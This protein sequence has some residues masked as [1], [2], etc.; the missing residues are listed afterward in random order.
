MTAYHIKHLPP[1]TLPGHGVAVWSVT[2]DGVASRSVSGGDVATWAVADAER[3]R[4]AAVPTVLAPAVGGWILAVLVAAAYVLLFGLSSASAAW[5]SEPGTGTDWLRY[6]GLI[7]LT[8][9]PLWYR[10]VPVAAIPA[11]VFVL[12]KRF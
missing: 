5:H 2:G 3:W 12:W 4:K 10:D 6:P 1:G 11:A 7:L 8:A 9:L